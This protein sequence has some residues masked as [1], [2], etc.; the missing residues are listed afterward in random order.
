MK[1]ELKTKPGFEWT[2]VNWGRPDSP[3]S[4]LCSYCSASLSEDDVPL[5]VWNKR[6]FTAQFC[7]ECQAKWWGMQ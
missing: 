4:V 7:A 2:K 6:D 5:I 1:F 3:R